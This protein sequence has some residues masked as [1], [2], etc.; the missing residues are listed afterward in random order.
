MSIDPT[1]LLSPAEAA[2][3][4]SMSVRAVYRAIADGELRAFRLRNRYRIATS[5]L[6][7][8]IVSGAVIN[9]RAS[10]ADVTSATS[11]RDHRFRERIGRV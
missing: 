10:V 2:T 9:S 3:R 1:P 8:W 6:D 11:A 4:C 5:D 7:A